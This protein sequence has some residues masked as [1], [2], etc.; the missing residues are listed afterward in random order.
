MKKQIDLEEIQEHLDPII[1][2]SLIDFQDFILQRIHLEERSEF[3]KSFNSHNEI[4]EENIFIQS[5]T[6]EEDNN[7]NMYVEILVERIQEVLEEME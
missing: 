6:L 2:Q 5:G 1:R 3:E 7:I 4:L